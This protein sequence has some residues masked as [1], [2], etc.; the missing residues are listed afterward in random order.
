MDNSP[1][2]KLVQPLPLL[3]DT[4]TGAGL[5]AS[6]KIATRHVPPPSLI[7]VIFSVNALTSVFC[8]FN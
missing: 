5:I 3:P 8:F 4:K 2:D 6:L 7:F 1:T